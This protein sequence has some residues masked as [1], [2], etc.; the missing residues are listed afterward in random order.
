MLEIWRQRVQTA[1]D[2]AQFIDAVGYCL[3][4][5]IKNLPLPSLYYA[6]APRYPATGDK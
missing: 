1:A 2:A 3:L 6:V 4:F 5:P